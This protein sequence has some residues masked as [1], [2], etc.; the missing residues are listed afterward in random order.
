[1]HSA[2]NMALI[3]LDHPAHYLGIGPFQVSVGNLVIIVSMFVIFALAI[4]IPFPHGKDE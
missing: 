2:L 4:F 1:M 3:N